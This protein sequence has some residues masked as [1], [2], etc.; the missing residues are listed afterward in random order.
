MVQ[1]AAHEL[2]RF[3]AAEYL[4][5]IEAGILTDQ[6]RV[7]LVDGEILNVAPQGPEHSSLKDEIHQRLAE[8]YRALDVHVRNQGPLRVGVYGVPEPDLAVVRGKS[9]D[10]LHAHPVGTDA[11]LVVEIAK[12]SQMRD[13]TKA[14]DCAR[15][16]VAVYWLLDLGARTLDVY[17]R[18]DTDAERY[19]SLVSLTERESVEL[20]DLGTSWLVSTLLP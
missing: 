1:Q 11:V 6:D 3:A 12:T 17:T 14:T 4:R 2:R 18:P 5:M 10:Y 8:A 13:R 16:D 15:G 7:E 19:R 9:R 20:P